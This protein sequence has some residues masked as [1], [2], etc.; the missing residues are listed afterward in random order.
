MAAS[1]E[2]KKCGI[3]R[4][5]QQLGGSHILKSGQDIVIQDQEEDGSDKG[6]SMNKRKNYSKTSERKDV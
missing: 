2:T 6:S 3:R 1:K 5:P 4:Q